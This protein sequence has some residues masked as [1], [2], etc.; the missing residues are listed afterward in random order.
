M[1]C[2]RVCLFVMCV[3]VWGGGEK[4]TAYGKDTDTDTDTGTYLFRS[5]FEIKQGN[6]LC[7][8]CWARHDVGQKYKQTKQKLAH[9]FNQELCGAHRNGQGL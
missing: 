6:N 1:V 8:W 3:C 7:S 4:R 2:V 9:G 5:T